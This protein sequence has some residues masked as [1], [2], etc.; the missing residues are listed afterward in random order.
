MTIPHKNTQTLCKNTYKTITQTHNKYATNNEAFMKLI[1]KFNE[2]SMEI[3]GDST[4]I[5][6]TCHGNS[7]EIPRQIHGNSEEFP[8]KFHG[9]SMQTLSEFHDNLKKMPW[10][11]HGNSMHML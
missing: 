9:N 2:H 10:A 1:W 7:M 11:R 5:P 4:D 6:W 3:H 8:R